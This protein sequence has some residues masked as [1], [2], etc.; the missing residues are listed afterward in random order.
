MQTITT[1]REE[2]MNNFRLLVLMNDLHDGFY[3]PSRFQR[4]RIRVKFFVRRLIER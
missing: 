3:Q 4:I 2:D 1:I